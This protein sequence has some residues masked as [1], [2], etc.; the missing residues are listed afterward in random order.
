MQVTGGAGPLHVVFNSR[1][2][3]GGPPKPTVIF[4]HGYPDT[5]RTWSLQMAALADTCHVVAFDLRG[6]GASAPPP[7]ERDYAIDAI[8][9]DVTAVIEAVAGPDDPV[10]LVAH[11]WGALICW[12]YVSDPV[13]ARRLASYTAIAGPHPDLA[14]ALLRHRLAS[15]KLSDLAEFFHQSAMSWYV[16]VFQIPG[17]AEWRWRR[18]WQGLWVGMHRKGGCPPGDPLLQAD[19]EEVLSGA[20]RPLNLYRQL[21]RGLSGGLHL[22]AEPIRVP[23]CLVIPDRDLALSPRLYDNVADYVADLT[24]EHLDA[25]HWVYRS[26]PDTINDLLRRFVAA[27]PGNSSPSLLVPLDGHG[28]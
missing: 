12:R 25:N 7:R 18:D 21:I 24:V 13:L 5:H 19:R 16:A 28:V 15:G 20:I 26:H 1:A 2:I 6:A 3:D 9:P 11:D 14:L 17:L 10:H 27:H 8:L 22:P 23:V 4:V